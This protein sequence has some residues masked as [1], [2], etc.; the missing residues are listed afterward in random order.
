MNGGASAT[1]AKDHAS[2]FFAVSNTAWYSLNG[3]RV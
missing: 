1:I 3:Q 2:V